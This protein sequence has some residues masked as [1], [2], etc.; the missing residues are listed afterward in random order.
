MLHGFIL[1]LMFYDW[2]ALKCFKMITICS[3]VPVFRLGVLNVVKITSLRGRQDDTITL[4]NELLCKKR[5]GYRIFPQNLAVYEVECKRTKMIHWR[6]YS[7]SYRHLE[8]LQDDMASG[9]ICQSLIS[10]KCTLEYSYSV[11]TG[12][13]TGQNLVMLNEHWYL[14]GKRIIFRVLLTFSS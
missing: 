5:W 11:E 6:V 2:S 3:C 12:K 7:R 1:S 9:I 10:F 4:A 13:N 14:G 8:Y